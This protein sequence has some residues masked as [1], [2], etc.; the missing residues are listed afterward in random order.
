M[1]G[2]H[3]NRVPLF[4]A[5]YQGLKTSPREVLKAMFAYCGLSD[6][7]IPNLDTVLAS[8]SQAGSELSRENLGA[9]TASLTADHLAEVR[10]LIADAADGITAETILANTYFPVAGSGLL[11]ERCDASAS[12]VSVLL[13]RKYVTLRPI[14]ETDN[15]IFVAP[16]LQSLPATEPKQLSAHPCRFDSFW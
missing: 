2:M 4:L 16:D 3:R 9:R 5:R 11:P 12:T 8:D 14:T 1:S 7:A 13:W 15:G 6:R 10:R